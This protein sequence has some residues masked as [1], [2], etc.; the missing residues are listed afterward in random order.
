MSAKQTRLFPD[1]LSG[2]SINV[3][4]LPFAENESCVPLK[5]PFI[6]AVSAV[7]ALVVIENLVILLA[8]VLYRSRLKHSNV[9]RYVASTLVA[10]LVTSAL[11]FY[12]FINYYYGIESAH[13]NHWWAFRK[14]MTLALSLVLC[15]N[16]GLMIYGIEDSTYIVGRVSMQTSEQSTRLDPKF[17]RRKANALI[18]VVWALPTIYGLLA[19]TD[20]NC[21]NLC[22]CTLSYK[23][24]KYLCP[25]GR[26]S[27]IYTPMSKSYLLVVVILWALECIGLLFLLCRSFC[28]IRGRGDG[29][30]SGGRKI[31][32][33]KALGKY[34][35]SHHTV[36]ILFILFVVCTAPIM[37]LFFADFIQQDAHFSHFLVNCITP[38]PLVYC[39]VSPILITQKLSGVRSALLMVMT[40]SWLKPQS[41]TGPKNGEKKTPQTPDSTNPTT[42]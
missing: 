26:C 37:G 17:R 6:H 35:A 29:S 3:S 1:V 7:P 18:C 38:L 33:R 13:P 27:H 25:V 2:N 28:N 14:G 41:N 40:F 15:G 21:T 11:G 8:L 20:W 30:E 39:V 19:M 36:T 5:E 34:H 12:H 32:I 22:S 23:S 16:I 42:H 31:S 24:G 10:N 4:T 9:Y